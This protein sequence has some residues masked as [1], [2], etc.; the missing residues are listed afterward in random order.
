MNIDGKLIAEEIKNRLKEKTLERDPKLSLG[1]I[2]TQETPATRQYAT[3]KQEFGKCIGVKVDLLRLGH[4]EQKDENLLQLLMHSTRKYDGLIVQLP[5]APQFFL[6]NV[7]NIL[8]LT[9]DVDVLGNTGYQQFKERNLPFLP[10]VIGAFS[11]IL[12]RS[13]VKLAGKKVV[14]FG[15][16]RLV[17]APAA[18]WAE[19]LG[20]TVTVVSKE[21]SDVPTLT[22]QADI[23]FLGAG[24]PGILKPDMIQE[25]VMILDAGSGQIDGVVQGD[26][27][28]ACAEK[29][30]LFSPTP[31]GV[32]PITVAKM[33]ENLVVLNELR[34][35]KRS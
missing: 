28:Q 21:T 18:V 31:G 26:A 8:P 35:K 10:P 9:H 32:G 16:G 4:F 2:V 3:L 25:G 20:A 19:Q 7:L 23:I 12:N 6:E 14:V 11:E 33:F 24:S 22:Q 1:I 27:D 17:G 29:S 15:E 5:L 13:S 34:N 30:S